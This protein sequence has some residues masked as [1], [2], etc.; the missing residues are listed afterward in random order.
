MV[1]GHTG[2]ASRK[3]P[4][5]SWV[6]RHA[7]ST[8]LGGGQCIGDAEVLTHHTKRRGDYNNAPRPHIEESEVSVLRGKL[9]VAEASTQRNGGN[10]APLSDIAAAGVR[11]TTA[12]ELRAAGFA[13]I[14]TCGFRGEESAHVSVVWPDGKPLDDQNPN[15][16]VTVQADFAACFTEGEA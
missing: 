9:T 3:P 4:G 15:W 12:G 16:P 1:T 13:V 11:Y 6:R 10:R 8:D 5:P 14:H 7:C 2:S